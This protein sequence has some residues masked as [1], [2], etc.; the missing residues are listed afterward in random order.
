MEVQP[1]ALQNAAVYWGLVVACKVAVGFCTLIATAVE[2]VLVLLVPRP[3]GGERVRSGPGDYC[4]R[5]RCTTGQRQYSSGYYRISSARNYVIP[6]GR[7]SYIYIYPVQFHYSLISA[8][9]K[10]VLVIFCLILL[11]W[12]HKIS[13]VWW[14]NI[15]TSAAGT[16]ANTGLSH[17]W[18]FTVSRQ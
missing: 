4:L 9:N 7:A 17:E 13:Q 8:K 14:P 16:S 1:K 2:W 12:Y 3:C 5:M 10:T 6:L 18:Y 11:P 15:C